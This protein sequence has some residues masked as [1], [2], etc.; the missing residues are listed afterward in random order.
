[1]SM[2]KVMPT[3]PHTSTIFCH[4]SRHILKLSHLLSSAPSPVL[5]HTLITTNLLV[6]RKLFCEF[7][8]FLCNINWVKSYQ[9]AMGKQA[10][11]AIGY[12]QLNRIETL[13]YLMVYPQQP[14]VKTKTIELIGYDKVCY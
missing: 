5:F 3:L 2:K 14:M 8:L 9:C 1:M 7:N 12:N 11:G 13:I 6:I 10:I 4:R